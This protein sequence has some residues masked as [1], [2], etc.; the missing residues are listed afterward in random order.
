MIGGSPVQVVVMDGDETGEELFEESL[1][2]LAPDLLGLTARPRTLRPLPGDRRAT[3]NEVVHEAAV[4]MRK[5]GLGLKAATITPE[6]AGDVG[7]PNA[8]LRKEMDGRVIVRTARRIPGFAPR[9]RVLPDL[10]RPHGGRG[11]LRGRGVA[12]GHWPRRWALPRP[13]GDPLNL[14]GSCE[15]AFQHARRT[16][17][18]SSAGRNGR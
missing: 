11:R 8:I 14:P 13:S 10:H 17:A 4:A 15:F 1:R 5:A 3:P 12:R 18:R 9:R 16:G 6:G 7:S 2:L